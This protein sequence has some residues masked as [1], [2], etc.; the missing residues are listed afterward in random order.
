MEDERFDAA[1]RSLGTGAT[2]RGVLG[3]LA[4]L[5]G[6]GLDE[7]AAKRRRRNKAQKGRNNG[8]R[9]QAAKAGKVDVC[10]YDAGANTYVRINISQ[11]GWDNGHSKHDNDYLRGGGCCTTADCTGE[12]EECVH[13]IGGN[14]ARSGACVVDC[15]AVPNGTA[16]DTQA[17][18]GRCCGGSCLNTQTDLNNCGA[19][20]N[21]CTAPPNG[22]ATCSNGVCGFTC[23]F[24]PCGG[25]CCPSG[26]NCSPDGCCTFV[27]DACDPDGPNTC[28]AAPRNFC[29]T[30]DGQSFCCGVSGVSPCSPNGPSDRCCSGTCR[31]LTCA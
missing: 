17:G 23:N 29:K 20:G 8:P 13:T 4:G 24:S 21:V 31:N 22:S 10:H 15:S 3:L 1:I 26:Q 2:R 11:N 19:C 7:V 9:A 18:R 5:T 30:V 12:F 28:C 27:R 16:C 25:T 6:L 14:G